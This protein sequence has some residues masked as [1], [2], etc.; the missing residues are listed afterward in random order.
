M[1]TFLTPDKLATIV[2]DVTATSCGTTFIPGDSFA[3]GEAVCGRVFI[4]PFN[5]DHHFSLLLSCDRPTSRTLASTLA[6]AAPDLMSDESV[7]PPIRELLG[8]ISGNLERTLHG[9]KLPP[10]PA[11]PSERASS[12]SSDTSDGVLLRS[13]GLAGIR[14]WIVERAGMVRTITDIP[15]DLDALQ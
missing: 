1:I 2:S 7:D 9:P 4:W 14:L 8:L 12:V 11:A 10:R 15:G 6:G 13:D 5:G 3:R